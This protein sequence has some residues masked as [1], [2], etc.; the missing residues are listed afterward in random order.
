M[1]CT[2]AGGSASSVVEI[3][4]SNCNTDFALNLSWDKNP[5]S[6]TG[7]RVF[8]GPTAE[9]VTEELTDIPLATEGFDPE[10]PTK[11]YHFSNDLGLALGDERCFRLKAYNDVGF[12]DFSDVACTALW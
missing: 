2:G 4:C 9:T 10:L 12:S 11:S 6:V 1:S 3:T 7:Y 8:S 5:D